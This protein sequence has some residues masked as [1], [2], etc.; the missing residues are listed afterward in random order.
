MAMHD[1]LTQVAN[2]ALFLSPPRNAQEEHHRT[3]YAYIVVMLIDLDEFKPV[4][5]T[6]S[7]CRRRPRPEAKCARR[8]GRRQM[9]R[10]SR[11]Y[12][13]EFV[14]AYGVQNHPPSMIRQA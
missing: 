11:A 4:S 14:L 13:D 9:R 2:R 6:R 3:S 8:I 12:G 10:S 7:T 5:T 1:E